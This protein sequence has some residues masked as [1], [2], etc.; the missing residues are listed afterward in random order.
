MAPGLTDTHTR[1]SPTLDRHPLKNIVP[2]GIKTSGQQNPVYTELRPYD[3]FPHGI[4]GPTLWK[5]EDYRDNPE[6]W[7]H[8]F[9]E[10][11]VA[12]MSEAADKFKAAALPLTGIS[13]VRHPVRSYEQQTHPRVG[14]L[15]TSKSVAIIE[16]HTVRTSQWQRFRS[17]QRLPSPGVGQSQVCDCIYGAWD[18]SRA[19]C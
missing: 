11:E 10:G 16:I 9:T 12:E 15:P 14:E 13:K 18:L 7:T 8:Y 6:Q 1:A 4:T 19:L 5:A 3:E 2:D 17:L